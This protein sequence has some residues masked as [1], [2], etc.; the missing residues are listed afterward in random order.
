MF[1]RIT[2]YVWTRPPQRGYSQ[3]SGEWSHPGENS[4]Q[5]VERLMSLRGAVVWPQLLPSKM[6]GGT[7]WLSNQEKGSSSA[8]GEQCFHRPCASKG[9]IPERMGEIDSYVPCSPAGVCKPRAP[10]DVSVFSM[11]EDRLLCR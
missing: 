8:C 7:I 9:E 5:A 3:K 2:H 6:V 4:Q 11:I 10:V 1:V